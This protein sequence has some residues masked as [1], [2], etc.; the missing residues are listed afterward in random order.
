ML[1]FE[2][3]HVLQTAA[4]LLAVKIDAGAADGDEIERTLGVRHVGML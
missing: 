4:G 2:R 1:V 3:P